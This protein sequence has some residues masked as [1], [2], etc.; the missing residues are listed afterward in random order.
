MSREELETLIFQ[1]DL[2]LTDDVSQLFT[3]PEEN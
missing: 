1:I 2:M 3:T